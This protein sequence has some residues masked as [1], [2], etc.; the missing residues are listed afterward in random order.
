MGVEQGLTK[1]AFIMLKNPILEVLN[2]SISRNTIVEMKFKLYDLAF[3]MDEKG[4][5]SLLFIGAEDN[6]GKIKGERY[7]HRLLEI[8]MAL[9]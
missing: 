5:Q 1:K 4:R 9:S 8:R 7:A 3:K 2:K 6:N